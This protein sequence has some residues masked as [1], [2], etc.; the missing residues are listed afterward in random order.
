MRLGFKLK[1]RDSGGSQPGDSNSCGDRL[2][3]RAPRGRAVRGSK[4]V[5]R[6][7]PPAALRASVVCIGGWRCPPPSRPPSLPYQYFRHSHST[8]SRTCHGRSFHVPASTLNVHVTVVAVDQ[9]D[10]IEIFPRRNLDPLERA[11]ANTER[12]SR[13][14]TP[15]SSLGKFHDRAVETG[16]RGVALLRG[17]VIRRVFSCRRTGRAG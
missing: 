7:P 3:R 5:K 9:R 10:V 11:P 15:A 4:V 14:S 8:P 12:V 16:E 2:G 1:I 6:R 13:P 17:S